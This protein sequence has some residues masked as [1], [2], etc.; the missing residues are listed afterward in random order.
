MA[1]SW[2]RVVRQLLKPIDSRASK[3]LQLPAQPVRCRGETL[4][5]SGGILR[6]SVSLANSYREC[7]H[8]CGN[9]VKLITLLPR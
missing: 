9:P 1:D 8:W 3:P 7:A 5:L 2:H 4:G 6:A